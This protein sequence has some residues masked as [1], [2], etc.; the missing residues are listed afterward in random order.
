MPT[1]IFKS[2]VTDASPRP[3]AVMV[4]PK[5]FKALESDG[6]IQRK[7]GTPN[8]LP[9]PSFGDKVPFYDEDIYVEC[10][11][12]LEG[13]SFNLPPASPL[14]HLIATDTPENI[15]YADLFEINGLNWMIQG[16][17]KTDAASIASGKKPDA[18]HATDAVAIIRDGDYLFGRF[19]PG[20]L[21]TKNTGISAM[22]KIDV[23]AYC[24][25]EEE[26][27]KAYAPRGGVREIVEADASLLSGLCATYPWPAYMAPQFFTQDEIAHFA[28][29]I[30]MIKRFR[31]LTDG[32]IGTR[33]LIV[34]Y[35]PSVEDKADLYRNFA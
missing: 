18:M 35:M 3:K 30:R 31:D 6:S 2:A 20:A 4:S 19:D 29:P 9:L 24:L 12:S 17:G 11:P 32:A 16:F 33:F 8:G 34:P 28:N 15:Y 5:L 21:S 14:G 26:T 23:I 25:N 13:F 1:T 27:I 7:I 10:N 22:H